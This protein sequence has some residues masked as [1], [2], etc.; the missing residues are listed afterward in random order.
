MC[1]FKSAIILKDRVFIPDYDSHS[2]MLDEL[3]IE[4]TRQNAEKLFIRAELSPENGDV[5]SNIDNWKFVVDQDILPG[6]YVKDYD[7]QRMIEAVKEWAKDRI[8][9]C[10]DNLK[11]N[12][13]ANHYIKDCKDVNIYG[14]ATVKNIY[15]SATVKNIY[16]GATVENICDSATVE[17]I[18]DSAT[19][20]N[21]YDSATVEYICD[22]A[23]VEYICDSATVK[24]ICGS[25]TVKN[26]CGSATVKNIYGSATVKN[27]YGGATVENICDSATVENICDSATVETAKGFS[28]I[29]TSPYSKF[30]NRDKLILLENATLKDCYE[31]KIYQS[32]DFK[33][34]S[35]S[36]GKCE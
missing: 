19:V 26:I 27:I 15:G 24:N 29:R 28:T 22:S 23:T 32:G 13:G 18:C 36:N 31:K 5:F 6:W 17:Y 20:K 11:I 3:G 12:S 2:D 9:I 25:A 14:S 4:D 35:V 1:R 21:I 10:V 7:K 8:H 33:L 30:N 16:G 34:V